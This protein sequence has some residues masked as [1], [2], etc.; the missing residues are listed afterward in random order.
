[1]FRLKCATY[2][3]EK[4][5]FCT[6]CN[7]YCALCTGASHQNIHFEKNK[8]KKIAVFRFLLLDGASVTALIIFVL[9]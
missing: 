1:M 7:V 9:E 5:K 2:I 8:N 3:Y 4:L 6:L